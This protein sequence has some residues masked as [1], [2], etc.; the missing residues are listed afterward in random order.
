[1]REQEICEIDSVIEIEWEGEKNYCSV[2][3]SGEGAQLK[4]AQAQSQQRQ[5]HTQRRL[6]GCP[7]MQNGAAQLIDW[8]IVCS[9]HFWTQSLELVKKEGQ[10]ING[11][12][13][14]SAVDAMPNQSSD[15]NHSTKQLTCEHAIDCVR[16]TVG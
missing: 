7:E 1:M 10:A 4:S 13:G 3:L 6:N 16:Q 8:Q 12:G 5:T 9:V 14:G 11:C 15:R 2:I